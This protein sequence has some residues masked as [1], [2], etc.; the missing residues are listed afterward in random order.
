MPHPAKT[1]LPKTPRRTELEPSDRE[2]FDAVVQNFG[3]EPGCDEFQFFGPFGFLMVSPPLCSIAERMGKFVR[4]VGDTPGSYSHKDREFVDQVLCADW[5]TN[6]VGAFHWND[7][8]ETGV[9]IEAIKA[10]RFGRE[11]ELDDDERLLARYIRQAVSGTVDDATWDAMKDRV[12]ERGV[13]E[14]TGFVLWLQWLMRMMQ[15]V[16]Y[17]DPTDEEIDALI[18]DLEAGKA[19]LD[20]RSRM[21]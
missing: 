8:V 15:A 21:R 17:P 16:G 3:G 13:L 11:E 9:R 5:K 2:T 4:S 20:Y 18:A 6:I 10:L 12:G 14:F 1:R 19:D 7:A